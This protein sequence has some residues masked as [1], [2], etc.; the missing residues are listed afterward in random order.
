MTATFLQETPGLGR[1][2]STSGDFLSKLQELREI[3]IPYPANIRDLAYFTLHRKEGLQK[4]N[5]INSFDVIITCHGILLTANSPAIITEISPLISYSLDHLKNPFTSKTFIDYPSL[6]KKIYN[7]WQ[8]I[9][10]EDEKLCPEKRR[11]IFIPE[12]GYRINISRESDLARFFFKDVREEFFD[13]YF[14]KSIDMLFSSPLNLVPFWQLSKEELKYDNKCVVNYISFTDNFSEIN[15][16]GSG[17]NNCDML[18]II[19]KPN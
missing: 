17:A 9:A 8:K 18:G 19:P 6:S 10:I 5:A 15:S 11:A 7:P 16:S 1:V 4:T 14:P 12:E 2:Y 13:F 3:G